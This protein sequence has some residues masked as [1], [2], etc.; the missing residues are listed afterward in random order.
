MTCH[1]YWEQINAMQPGPE[2][3]KQVAQKITGDDP[4]ITWECLNEKGNA[5]CMSGDSKREVQ[6]WLEGTLKRC[7][8]SWVKNYHVGKWEHWPRYSEKHDLAW[9]VWE[10]VRKRGND[11][12]INNHE[13]GVRV[14]VE[15]DCHGPQFQIVA[16]TFPEAMCK[17]ALLD[18]AW[19]GPAAGEQHEQG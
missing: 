10:A 4:R 16:P 1:E 7:P 12:Q 11:I 13:K 3:D 14:L 6:E 9:S 2:L 17:V 8:D 5:T 15:D 18:Y 19:R